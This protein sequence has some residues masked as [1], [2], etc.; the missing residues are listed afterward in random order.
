MPTTGFSVS[1]STR[2]TRTHVTVTADGF[3]NGTPN[4]SV[5]HSFLD[6][7][8]SSFVFTVVVRRLNLIKKTFIIYLCV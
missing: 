2:V 7:T 8:F 5:R 3:I 6:R 1:G 4:G